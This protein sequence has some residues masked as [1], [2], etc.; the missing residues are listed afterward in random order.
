MTVVSAQ[1]ALSPLWLERERLYGMVNAATS[2]AEAETMMDR[3]GAA[4]T[5]ILRGPINSRADAAAKARMA[6][7]GMEAGLRGDGSDVASIRHLARSGWRR[8]SWHTFGKPF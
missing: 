6:L 1:P 3:L 2:E 5:A 7:Y 8:D 4:E